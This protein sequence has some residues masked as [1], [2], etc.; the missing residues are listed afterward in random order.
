MK[1]GPRNKWRKTVYQIWAEFPDLKF[2]L[3][4]H[5]CLGFLFL[6]TYTYLRLILKTVTHEYRD[7][8]TYI[9]CVKLLRLYTIGFC[10]RVFPDFYCWWSEELCSQQ[11]LIESLG[12]VT[13]LGSM[14][15][16]TH[17]LEV[18]ASRERGILQDQ[19]QLDIGA[20]VQL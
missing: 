17:K 15:R 3:V 8:K 2:S 18:C 12:L 4:L 7:Q 11:H 20:K 5:I 9:L 19:V 16:V 14:Q 10:N 1:I 13:Y 6:H